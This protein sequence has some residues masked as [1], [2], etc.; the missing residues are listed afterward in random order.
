MYSTSSDTG[1]L[2]ECANAL[3]H[4]HRLQLLELLRGGPLS[5]DELAR[6]TGLTMSNTS[7]H[8]QILRRSGFVDPERRGKQIFYSLSSIT[9]YSALVTVLRAVRERHAS[10]IG[11][12]RSDYLRAQ[13]LLEPISR[14]ELVARLREGLVTVIDVRPEN[15]YAT[16]HIAGAINIPLSDLQTHLGKFESGREII[17][18]CRGAHCILSFEAVAALQAFGFRARRLDS[19]LAEWTIAG[20]AV[21]PMP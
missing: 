11:Q 8:L 10:I 6:R 5:V 9:E 15:E 21:A 12:L 16:G 4:A 13:E 1:A 20:L 14:D 17:A 18:Y 3:A 2:A 19:D 7:R